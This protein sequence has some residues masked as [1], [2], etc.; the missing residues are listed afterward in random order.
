VR[1]RRAYGSGTLF[2]RPAGRWVAQVGYRGTDGRRKYLTRVARD[3]RSATF[4]LQA[5]LA[6][7][8]AGR[9][10]A[11]GQQ[12]LDT[13][14]DAWLTKVADTVRATTLRSYRGH[15]ELHVSPLL[16]GIP[17]E[18]LRVVDVERL[19]RSRRAAGKAPATIRRILTTLGMAL[20]E[21]VTDGLLARNVARQVKRPKVEYRAISAMTAERAREVLAAVAADRDAAL[22][23]LLLGSGL[24]VGEALALDWRDVDLEYGTVFVRRGKTAR[25]TRTIPVPPSVV[26]ALRAHR[27]RSSTIDP[28]APVF[29]GSRKGERL[30][31]DVVTHR[32]PRLL[33][34]AG[35]PRLRVH[36]LRHAHATLLLA[37]GVPMQMI[38]DQLGHANPAVTANV[39][40][41]VQP[42]ALRQ[43]VDALDDYIR[44]G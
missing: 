43:A 13:F 31:V 15:V 41:H 21:A 5:L 33:E 12:T 24:R 23:V 30:R 27:A 10:A 3:E 37:A 25:S 22:Y 28:A 36:D 20:E 4:A 11:D 42:G 38:A 14:L 6:R 26:A 29:T 44:H 1:R 18:E 40:A 9:T 35:L 2:R 32:L 39:Y 17:I 16:G 34:A 7:V 8:G 19:I